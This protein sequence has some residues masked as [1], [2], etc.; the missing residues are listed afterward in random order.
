MNEDFCITLDRWKNEFFYV[1]NFYEIALRKA[2]GYLWVHAHVINSKSKE[3]IVYMTLV[4]SFIG[5]VGV[6]KLNQ[7]RF[8]LVEELDNP[9][10]NILV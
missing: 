6:Q 3:D 8:E 1:N 4:N 10:R 5:D 2:Q 7:F 9:T